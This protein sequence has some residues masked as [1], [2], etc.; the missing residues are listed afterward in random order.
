MVSY[1]S[2]EKPKVTPELLAFAKTMGLVPLTIILVPPG[3]QPPDDVGGVSFVALVDYI[4]RIGE[5]I[6]SQDN[7]WCVV[8]QV[9][10]KVWKY[11]GVQTPAFSLAPSVFAEVLE[12]P[13]ES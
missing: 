13:S 12:R 1:D 3:A 11:D 5:H 4:P 10:H 6:V 9:V 7:Q 2:G 8:K